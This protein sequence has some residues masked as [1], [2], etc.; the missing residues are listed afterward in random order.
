MKAKKKPIEKLEP[1][2]LGVD[3]TPRLETLK[4]EEPAK[5]VG[6]GKVCVSMAMLFILHADSW[7][8]TGGECGRAGGEAQGAWL[9]GD[10]ITINTNM[11]T[12][13]SSS[14]S[15]CIDVIKYTITITIVDSNV[16]VSSACTMLW[17]EV[18]L[19]VKQARRSCSL[20]VSICE[21]RCSGSTLQLQ[22]Q[23]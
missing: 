20:V 10:R 5:R 3:L 8:T 6:G 2:E 7:M 13:M 1:S 17:F 9:H 23:L 19:K 22:I 11:E 18:H 15:D 21:W 4:V 12:G 14:V 16:L